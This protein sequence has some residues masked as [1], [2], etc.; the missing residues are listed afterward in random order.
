MQASNAGKLGELRNRKDAAYTQQ[1]AKQ[2]L[3][4]NS[5]EQNEAFLRVAER[6]V[7]QQDAAIAAPAA[8]R[9][10]IPQ[11]GRVLT[12]KR[13]VQV[14]TMTD[15]RIAIEAGSAQAAPG[16]ARLAMLAALALIL[17]ALAWATH[18]LRTRP[19]AR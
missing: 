13:S 6:L 17:G 5:A 12:F 15:L 10:A 8:I 4:G 2:I 16:A 9:A 1:E 14:D 19:R 18:S 11:Q 3:E 7:Q